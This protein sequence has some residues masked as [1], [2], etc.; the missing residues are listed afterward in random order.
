MNGVQSLG[1]FDKRQANA[2]ALSSGCHAVSM[3]GDID[4]EALKEVAKWDL[5]NPWAMYYEI[6][7]T[8]PLIAKRL[9]MLGQ[10]ARVLGQP[11]YVEFDER[12]PESYWDDFLLDVI[13]SSLPM[14][15]VVAG[16]FVMVFFR[17][18]PLC[19]FCHQT[20]AGGL[21]FLFLGISFLVKTLYMYSSTHF[22]PM[23]IQGLLKKIKVSAVNPA[24]CV[25]R[26]KII[27]RGVPGL[28]YS[29]D[30]VLQDKTGIIF[31]DYQQP[32]AVW[33]FL[34]GLFRAA[35]YQN[36]EA[37]IVGWYR[38]SPIP[39]IEVKSMTVNG[40][41]SVCYVYHLKIISALAVLALG[42]FLLL[43]M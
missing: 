31:L 23:T 11:P 1:I 7:S 9:M 26:G 25:V 2:L 22:M 34:F 21:F 6:H 39:Y 14:I 18:A 32:L 15:T 12:K 17:G 41:T 42:V 33:N 3:G 38:R 30:F 40:K 8:H 29:E 36:Q 19:G 35:H 24:A 27:G 10:Q 28:I 20:K 43:M 4:R 37:E 13:V 5:W 16:L